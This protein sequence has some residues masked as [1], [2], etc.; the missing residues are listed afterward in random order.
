MFEHWGE[1]IYWRQ[2]TW[3]A[4]AALVAIV[5]AGFVGWRQVG[6][7]HRQTEIQ[8]LGIKVA[9][10]EERL[11]AYDATR[12]FI[13]HILR[14]GAVPGRKTLAN[15]M[16]GGPVTLPQVAIDFYD[17]MDRSRFLFAPETRAAL[18]RIYALAMEL[19]DLRGSADTFYEDD[20]GVRHTRSQDIRNQL[21]EIYMDVAAL[22]GDEL[23]LMPAPPAENFW[24]VR[25]WS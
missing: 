1:A 21:A 12:F 14:S 16:N 20:K 6:V 15:N 2:M 19:G 7:Q 22:F 18:D 4:F 10:R 24:R 3:E 9:L 17:A 5:A 11:K 8:A 13:G 25:V 23:N